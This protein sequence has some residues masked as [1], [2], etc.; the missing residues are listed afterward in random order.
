MLARAYMF[1]VKR[2]SFSLGCCFYGVVSAVSDYPEETEL[3]PRFL[4]A[5]IAQPY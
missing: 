3:F 2:F 1:I 4:I 5:E